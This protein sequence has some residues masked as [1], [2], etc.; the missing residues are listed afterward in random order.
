MTLE[1]CQLLSTAHRVLDGKEYNDISFG[2]KI[3]R[4]YL[5]SSY[6]GILYK[7]T[8]VNHP[9]A[10]WCRDGYE[11]YIWLAKMVKELAKEYTYRYGKIHKC[12]AIGLIDILQNA[13]KNISMKEFYEP[14]PAM[15]VEYI[16]KSSSIVSYRNYYIHGKKHLAKWTK[17]EIPEFYKKVLD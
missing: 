2:R 3:K 15:P 12:E 14:T 8:H 4:W 9:S 16:D 17:R 10:I 5:D 1:L 13:P 6:E 11:N 7:A